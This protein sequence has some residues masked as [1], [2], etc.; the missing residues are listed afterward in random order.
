V[1]EISW[2]KPW[3]FSENREFLFIG[4]IPLPQGLLTDIECLHY[5]QICSDKTSKEQ[6]ENELEPCGGCASLNAEA[7]VRN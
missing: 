5:G 6:L 7:D 3:N 4:L 2:R 1:V